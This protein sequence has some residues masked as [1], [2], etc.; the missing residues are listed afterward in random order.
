MQRYFWHLLLLGGVSACVA[1]PTEALAQG[2]KKEMS[3]D[4]VTIA[5]A[6]SAI[7]KHW[8]KETPADKAVVAKFDLGK[9]KE[10]EKSD[11]AELTFIKVE[12]KKTMA[13]I[14]SDE[15]KLIKDE[16]AKPRDPTDVTAGPMKGKQVYVVGTPTGK[17]ERFRLVSTV[18]DT[19]DG[20]YIVRLWGPSQLLGVHQPDVDQFLKA[21]KK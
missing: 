18:L 12:G 21:F 3:T 5:G 15:A 20:L 10:M 11:T 19:P 16:K 14:L 4:K 17:T 8:K 9:P 1:M 2:S 13:E 6:S 7:F